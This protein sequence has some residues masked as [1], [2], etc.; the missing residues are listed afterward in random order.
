[1]KK[2]LALALCLAIG[3]FSSVSVFATYTDSNVALFD[4]LTTALSIIAMWQ[5]SRKYI[6][7]W[8]VWLIVDI[9]S[10]GLYIYKGIYFYASLY[11]VYSIVAII[12]YIH[13]KKL[14]NNDNN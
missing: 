2:I 11:F 5:L 7:Q 6:E 8:I 14:M 9:I 1:M 4:A 13:W 12:G 3:I 10:V